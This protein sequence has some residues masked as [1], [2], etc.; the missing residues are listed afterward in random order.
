[1]TELLFEVANV[2]KCFSTF[3]LRDCSLSIFPGET[4]GLVG[5]SGSGKSTLGRCLIRLEELDKGSIFYKGQEIGQ[6]DASALRAFRK[7]V[8]MIFQDPFA[9]LNPK[10]D[11]ATLITEP[12]RIHKIQNPTPIDEL[13]DW[14]GLSPSLAMRRPHELSGGQLQRVNIARALALNPQFLICDEPISSLDV[15]I[16]AQIVNLLKKL[17]KERGLSYLFISHHLPMVR[18][19]ADRIA[20]MYMGHILEVAS[21]ENLCATPLHPYTQMLFAAIPIPD[22]VAAR[23]QKLPVYPANP[24]S[25]RGCPFASRCPRAQAV[26]QELPPL[27]EH[28]SQHWVRCHFP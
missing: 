20:V 28:A 14:V 9:S 7:E 13:L 2:D 3:A 6:F 16:Q 22:P 15:S 19:L 11:V 5:E 24:P 10:M 8:Q 18:Y 4:L 27:V 26:C 21:A 12:A 1:M 25:K 17:Q 23:A